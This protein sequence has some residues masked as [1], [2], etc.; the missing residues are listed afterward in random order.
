[1][2]VYFFEYL[3][4]ENIVF[5]PSAHNTYYYAIKR[6]KKTFFGRKYVTYFLLAWRLFLEI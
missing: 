1:M 5:R 3:D 6:A 4:I 2:K